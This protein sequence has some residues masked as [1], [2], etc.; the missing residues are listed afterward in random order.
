MRRHRYHLR[1]FQRLR[2][3]LAGVVDLVLFLVLVPVVLIL[4][5]RDPV[6]PPL[7]PQRLRQSPLEDASHRA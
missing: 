4:A 5:R 7:S 3:A 2:A 6:R 1:P